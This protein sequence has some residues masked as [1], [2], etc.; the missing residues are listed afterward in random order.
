MTKQMHDLVENSR[1]RVENI[2][3]HSS[4]QENINNRTN[5][6]FNSVE[7]VAKDLLELSNI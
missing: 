3:E 7:S 6:T 2:V 1:I 5:E 4:E